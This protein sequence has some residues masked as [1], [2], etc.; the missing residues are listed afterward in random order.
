MHIVPIDIARAICIV[1]VVLGHY[2][3]SNAPDWYIA[4]RSVIYSFHMP[5]FMFASGY[6]Y[7]VTKKN[8]PY[9]DFVWK[10]FQRLMIPYFFVST[11][12]ISIKLITERGLLVEAPVSFAAFYEMFYLP[13]AGAFAWF[14]YTLFLIFLIVTW[15]NSLKKILFLLALAL[16]LHFAPLHFPAIFCLGSV[17]NMLV[18]FV[19]GCAICELAILRHFVNRIHFLF[20]GLC[21]ILLYT[22][23]PE[24]RFALA[25]LGIVFVCG[26]SRFIAQRTALAKKLLLG[27]A[28]CSYTIYLFHT[29][30]MGFT[31]SM[32]HKI[33][34]TTYIGEDGAFAVSVILVV[35]VGVIAP[36]ILHKALTTRSKVG[37]YLIGAK[38]NPSGR[39]R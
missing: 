19:L 16:V 35:S 11:L 4:L 17:K 12:V 2:I 8:I 37:S 10:K 15:F 23:F 28:A 25:L 7:W 13:V 1:L 27:I 36:I 9:K 3:P 14:I 34:L 39:F 33:S 21:F 5:I 18:Y 24:S 38:F 30:F 6:V 29:T 20:F 31:K 26:L 22:Q 32:L